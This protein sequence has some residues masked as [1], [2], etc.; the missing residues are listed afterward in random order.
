MEDGQ[1]CLGQQRYSVLITE[2]VPLDENVRKALGLEPCILE[3]GEEGLYLAEDDDNAAGARGFGGTDV[4]PGSA[5]GC[6]S[7][8]DRIR[9]V[10]PQRGTPVAC[11]ALQTNSGT[12]TRA[13]SMTEGA[14][15]NRVKRGEAPEAPEAPYLRVSWVRKEGVD[16]FLMVNEGE[17]EIRCMIT[18]AA[19][20][21]AEWW[22]PWTGR[23]EQAV[24]DRE[25][26]FALLLPR[27]GSLILC[28][29]PDGATASAEAAVP[30]FA[31]PEYPQIHALARQNWRVT[32][33][34]GEASSFTLTADADGRLP[35]WTEQ[36]GLARYSGWMA[37]ETELSLPRD[38]LLTLGDTRAMSRLFLDGQEAGMC[39]WSPH[40][41]PIPAG[42]HALRLEICNTLANAYEGK[43]LPSG[44]MGPVTLQ[45]ED[46]EE[47]L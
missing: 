31:L 13:L 21:A 44:L 34:A 17:A 47:S 14:Q 28:V 26:R 15:P 9:A 18:P 7:R 36:P 25:G 42:R 37:Y 32:P 19:R 40:Q 45:Q 43:P 24:A 11:R 1:L 8:R 10:T 38:A 6:A 46:G 22:D 5:A 27:R 3:I 29:D 12:L 33:L 4:P 41:Y 30:P 39:M 23:T 35:S 20:G 2:E 16:L